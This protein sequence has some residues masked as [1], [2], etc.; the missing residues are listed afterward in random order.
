M[1]FIVL[2]YIDPGLGALL[3]QTIVAAFVG[4]LFYLK[5]TRQWIVDSVLKLFGRRRDAKAT[6]VGPKA[7]RKESKTEVP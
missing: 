7:A 1:K 3:W 6:P 4:L 2:A 5:K